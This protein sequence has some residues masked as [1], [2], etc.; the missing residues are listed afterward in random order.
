MEVGVVMH[1]SWSSTLNHGYLKTSARFAKE[2]GGVLAIYTGVHVIDRVMKE[3]WWEPSPCCRG[4][5]PNR[6]EVSRH[7]DAGADEGRG[8][9]D[10]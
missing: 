4:R 10:I 8:P 9:V 7:G 6:R 3:L 5:D 1:L 2:M